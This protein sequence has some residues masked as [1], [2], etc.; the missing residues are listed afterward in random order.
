ME[1]IPWSPLYPACIHGT[2]VE[3]GRVALLEQS[4]IRTIKAGP[5]A[6]WN[7]EGLPQKPAHE[8]IPAIQGATLTPLSHPGFP[9]V[10]LIHH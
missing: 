3:E 6:R 5:G 8:E 2:M 1:S 9:E 7:C 4:S 10:V